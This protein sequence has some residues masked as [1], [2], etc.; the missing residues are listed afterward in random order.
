MRR[1]QVQTIILGGVATNFGVGSTARAAFDRGYEI[2]F[3]EDALSNVTAE[4]HNFSVKMTFPHMRTVRRTQQISEAFNRAGRNR[5]G[6][7]CVG[8]NRVKPT[9]AGE[10]L[11]ACQLPLPW[12]G[13]L[14]VALPPLADD[15]LQF[16]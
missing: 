8:S 9:S 6:D 2:V 15:V 1:R 5:G 4:A 10:L 12:D 14:A 7:D 13:A 11:R 3:T 16:Q